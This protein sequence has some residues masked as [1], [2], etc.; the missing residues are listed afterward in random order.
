M[1]RFREPDADA[2]LSIA[3]CELPDGLAPGDAGWRDLLARVAATRPQALLLN[4]LPFGEW[5]AA[6]P[7]FDLRRAGRVVAGHAEGVAALDGLDVP[8]LFGSTALPGENGLVNEGFVRAGGTYRALHHKLCLPEEPGFH[9]NSWFRPG[10]RSFGL[11]DHGGF[12]F[13][14]AICSELM[15]PEVGR[16]LVRAGADVLLVPR[17]STAAGL[18]RWLT[19]ARATALVNGC[20]VASSNRNGGGSPGGPA[21]GGVG[22]VVDPAGE[23]L[24][25]TEPA[26]PL[27]TAVLSRAA[28][29]RARDGYPMTIRAHLAFAPPR[30]V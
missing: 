21:F 7:G 14:F 3:V 10:P 28:L 1:S 22:F 15:V 13:A 16:T 5:P 17:A 27:A 24:A 23:I 29:A 26:R 2:R 4:E 12:R 30:P 6:D 25:L 18:E 20:Y 9:E 11:F 8:V 19:V